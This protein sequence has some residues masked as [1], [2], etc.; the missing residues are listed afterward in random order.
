MERENCSHRSYT[1]QIHAD[2]DQRGLKSSPQVLILPNASFL[3]GVS[4]RG[5][6]YEHIHPDDKQR[7]SLEAADMFLSGKPLR[8]S[9]RVIARDGRESSSNNHL[10]FCEMRIQ[11][12]S[13]DVPCH[14]PC[15]GQCVRR[16]AHAVVRIRREKN[17]SV[18]QP[19]NHGCLTFRSARYHNSTS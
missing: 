1:A 13:G 17:H 14:L 18:C 12:T 15:P 10:I 19:F 16:Q 9:Y 4:E 7:W 8:S 3:P 6:W 2:F 5:F 11:G